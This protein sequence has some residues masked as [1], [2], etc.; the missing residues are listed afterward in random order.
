MYKIKKIILDETLTYLP[1]HMVSDQCLFNKIYHVLITKGHQE[2]L[3]A[4]KRLYV[5]PGGTR[6]HQ[7]AFPAIR[8]L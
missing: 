5:P 8:M 1:F 4:T 6:C 7:Q 3:G 2:A